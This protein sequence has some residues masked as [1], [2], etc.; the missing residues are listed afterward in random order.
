MNIIPLTRTEVNDVITGITKLPREI[1]SDFDHKAEVALIALHLKNRRV[2]VAEM[3]IR[4]LPKICM[5]IRGDLNAILFNTAVA[6]LA[7]PFQ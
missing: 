7:R 1:N 5:R 2:I 3:V 6:G 4:I